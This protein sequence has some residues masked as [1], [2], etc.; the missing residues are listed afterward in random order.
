MK[1]NFK[2]LFILLLCVIASITAVN[3]EAILSTFKATS[4]TIEAPIDFATDF[5]VIKTTDGKHVYCLQYNKKSPSSNIN[6][7]KASLIT[8]NGINYILNKA[9]NT[10][11]DEEHYIYKSALWIYMVDKG[12]MEGTNN[13]IKQYKK[14]VESSKL[15]IAKQILELVDSAK[16]ASANDTTAPTIKVNNNNAGFTLDSAGKYYVSS[17]IIV[18]S[19][20]SSYEVTLTDAPKDSIVSKDGNTFTIKVPASSVTNLNTKVS[21]KVSN[22]KEVYVSYRYNP[23]NSIYQPLAATY[24]EIKTA[25]AT[26][27]VSLNRTVSVPFLKV[28]AETGEAI[29]G[30]ELKLTNSKGEVIKTWTSTTKEEV[31]TGLTAGEYTLTETKAPVGYKAINAS[32]KFTIDKNGNI[33]DDNGK[34]IVQVV[35]I[36]EK[37][38]NGVYIS[39]QDITTKEE[40]PG[41]T[42]QIK[43]ANGNTKDEWTWVST[44]KP[45]YIEKLLP[46]TYT[47]TEIYAPVG[48]LLSK[49][50]IEFT[51]K[52]DGKIETV[53]MYNTPKGG[54]VI[55]KQDIT[56]KEELK[57]ATLQVKDYDGNI[58]DEWVS[59]DKP[60][61]I[62][63]L[64]PGIYTLREIYAPEGYILSDEIITFIVKDDGTITKVVM[65]NTPNSKDVPVEST[66]SFKTMTSGVIGSLVIILGGYIVFRNYKKKEEI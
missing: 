17:A 66:A 58:I 43:D 24:K 13:N 37:Q 64:D 57:G 50:T 12:L 16:K 19:S 62:E 41:A 27:S 36:N 56:N 61:Y 22:T 6:Y 33:L 52:A 39:K 46:G 4:K 11:S 40:L 30:A 35:I 20:T 28:D 51:V 54:V 65:Y 8:D 21:F 44:D 29:N 18:T 60:H 14:N 7:T 34:K 10:K 55:S 59:E 31:I 1:K 32:V 25:E 49:E 45:H 2:R 15:P 26:S 48:Y 3:A 42:L 5:H 9:Y 53:V 38:T 63:K 23:N 47:L